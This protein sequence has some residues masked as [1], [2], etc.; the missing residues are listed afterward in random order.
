MPEDY[1]PYHTL[2]AFD[3]G[4]D[5]YMSSRFKNL[6]DAKAS[7]RKH[8]TESANTRCMWSGTMTA[9]TTE[10]IPTTTAE[11]RAL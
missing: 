4:I 8:G 7:T 3:Q 11:N 10:F 2:P 1:A 6:Y 5:D 9:M